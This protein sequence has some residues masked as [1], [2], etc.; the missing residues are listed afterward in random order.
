MKAS[1][2]ALAGLFC[3]M[4]VLTASAEEN[5]LTKL[6]ARFKTRYPTLV[7]LKNG[8][9]IGETYKGNVEAVKAA[10]LEEKAVGEKKV[11]VFLAEENKDRARL[12][13]L[14]AKSA[15]TAPEKVVARAVKRNFSKAEPKHWLKVKSG[16]WVQ[17]KDYK[18]ESR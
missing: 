11:K 2:I 9:K 17:K 4:L 12:Y 8:G 16:K 15:G 7:K 13:V 14:M 1:T 3:L 10:Y 6:K 5:E 18:P